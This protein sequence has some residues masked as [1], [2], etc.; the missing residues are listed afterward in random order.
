MAEI[1]TKR[2]YVAT[3]PEDGRRILVDRL[4]PRGVSTKDADLDDWVR[5]LA[6]SNALRTWFDHDPEKFEAFGRKYARELREQERIIGREL[7]RAIKRSGGVLTLLYAAKDETHNH[8]MVLR[9]VMETYVDGV[10]ERLGM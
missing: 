3:T 4:W 2:I 7:E 10:R 6:P 9:E 8:A 5:E 1:R